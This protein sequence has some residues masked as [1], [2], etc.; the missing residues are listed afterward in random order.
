MGPCQISVKV[1]QVA[2]ESDV[3]CVI[4]LVKAEPGDPRI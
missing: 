2:K 4:T 1:S 3:G